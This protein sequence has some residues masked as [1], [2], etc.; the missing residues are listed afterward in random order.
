MNLKS[1][2]VVITGSGSGIGLAFAEKCAQLK[3]HLILVQRKFKSDDEQ[4]FLSLGALS[5][6]CLQADLTS[7]EQIQNICE[8]IKVKKIDVLFNNA[9]LLTG[10][11]LE[12]QPLD[13][14]Y[15]ML[16]VN[17][18]ALIHLTH[19]LLPQ[20]IQQKSGYVI[21]HASVSAVMHMPCASTYA[22]AKAAV[23][24]FTDCLHH[25]LK[26]TGVGTLCLFTPGIKTKMFDQINDL[27]SKNMKVPDQTISTEQY[28]SQIV[29]A[30]EENKS[31]LYPTGATG[32]AFWAATYAKTLFN[33][34]LNQAFKGR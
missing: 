19:Q 25:E 2:T 22:A 8:Q 5:V 4:K 23:W 26:S 31:N 34:G 27:Y 17:V 28:V 1:Q 9:G 13:Q 12:D 30:I 21:N 24:A 6:T 15:D 18:N 10:G 7:R 29:K 16:H 3:N 14:I 32:V 33:F 20:L 11:L